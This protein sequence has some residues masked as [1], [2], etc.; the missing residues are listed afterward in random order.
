MGWLPGIG[1]G[2]SR[3]DNNNSFPIAV[4]C[5]FVSVS[6]LEVI[7]VKLKAGSPLIL[8]DHLNESAS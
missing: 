4:G 3:V 5:I 8:T 7:D 2:V 6:G 1:G